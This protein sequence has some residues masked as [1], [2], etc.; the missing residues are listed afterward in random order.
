MANFIFVSEPALVCSYIPLVAGPPAERF[1]VSDENAG[2][3]REEG[4]ASSPSGILGSIVPLS[5]RLCT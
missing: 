3:Y 4:I 5:T 1:D 2:P